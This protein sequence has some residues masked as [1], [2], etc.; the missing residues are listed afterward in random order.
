MILRDAGLIRGLLYQ[1][2][3]ILRR[4]ASVMHRIVFIAGCWRSG[5]TLLGDLLGAVPGYCHVGEMHHVWRRGLELNWLCGCGRPFRSCEFWQEVIAE[6]RAAAGASR[7]EEL[8]AARRS[9]ANELGS[10]ATPSLIRDIQPQYVDAVRCLVSAVFQVSGASVVVDSSKSYRQACTLLA[11]GKVELVVVHLVRDPRATVFSLVERPKR[12][13]DDPQGSAMLNP[14]VESAVSLWSSSNY[15]A[16]RLG[17]LASK[18]VV[19]RYEDLVSEPRAV[20]ERIIEFAGTPACDVE[21]FA[22]PVDLAR[23]KR[24]HTVS[25]NPDRLRDEART[26][27]RLD[28]EWSRRMDRSMREFVEEHTRER[29]ERYSYR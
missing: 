20:I 4:T 23:I 15:E 29:M 26:E 18:Y 19:Q 10:T 11:G 28:D 2:C 21:G 14:D 3:I 6:W 1:G 27:V 7:A 22:E 12:R 13:F 9:I 24:S 16:E 5:S 8:E 17:Q 25:G